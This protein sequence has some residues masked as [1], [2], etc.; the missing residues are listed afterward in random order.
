MDVDQIADLRSALLTKQVLC[1]DL[2]KSAYGIIER[3]TGMV[4]K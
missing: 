4:E 2:Q 3:L 1:R